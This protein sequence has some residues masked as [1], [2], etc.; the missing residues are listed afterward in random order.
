MPRKPRRAVHRAE[1][2]N[3]RAISARIISIRN[4]KVILD[5]DIAALYGVST[6]ALNQ[7]VTRNITRFP[8]D[9]AFTISAMEARN[10]ISQSVISSSHG[11][12]RR[13]PRAFTEHG[14]A[15]LSSVLKSHRAVLANIA[16]MRALVRLR[17]V[18]QTHQELTA[19]LD[20]LERKFDG[21]FAVVFNAIRR[22]VD[23]P[24]EPE[25]PRKRIGFVVDQLTRVARDRS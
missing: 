23:A 14:V 21:K 9:F 7:A 20:H 10:L 18:A 13:L 19:R 8:P 22:I 17:A 5:R 4:L 16:I 24:A 12:T 11:G 6:S 3:T 1:R 15:M 2:G 25:E